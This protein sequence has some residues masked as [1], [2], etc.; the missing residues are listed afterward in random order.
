[1]GAP[2]KWF[3]I[4]T[5]DPAAVRAFYAEVF[6][7]GLQVLEQDGYAMVDTGGE[8]GIAGGIGEADGPNQITFYVEVDD[9]QAYLDK[10][11]EAGGKTLVP[12]TETPTW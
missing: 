6:G 12:V 11:V 10:I 8:G 5:T 7:W 1:M 4:S 9:P 2:V 3:E